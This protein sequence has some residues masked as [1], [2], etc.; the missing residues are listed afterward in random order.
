MIDMDDASERVAAFIGYLDESIKRQTASMKTNETDRF[1]DT[2]RLFDNYALLTPILLGGSA[3]NVVAKYPNV[4]YHLNR[5][6]VDSLYSYQKCIADWPGFDQWKRGLRSCFDAGLLS[7]ARYKAESPYNRSFIA[8]EG[9]EPFICNW[10][11][12]REQIFIIHFMYEM[13]LRRMDSRVFF[14]TFE[15]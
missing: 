4:A 1:I 7:G 13:E 14:N 3:G 8:F 11:K 12:D 2:L 6:S 15:F 10:S 9:I 5:L